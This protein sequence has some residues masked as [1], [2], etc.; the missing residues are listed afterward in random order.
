MP[1]KIHKMLLCFAIVFGSFYWSMAQD[2][3]NQN[4]IYSLPGSF[5]LNAKSDGVKGTP[6]LFEVTRLGKI[7]LPG[8]KV[9]EEIPFN[10]LLEKNEVY[11]QMGGE[12][13]PPMVVKKWDWIE[14]LEDNPRTFKTETVGGQARVVELIYEKDK[15]KIIAIHSKTLVKNEIVRDGYSGPQYDTYRHNVQFYKMEAVRSEE[16]KLNNAGL[17]SIAG[18]RFEELKE[19]IKLEKLK[20][21]EPQDLRRIFIFLETAK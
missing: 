1:S 2:L 8:G 3:Q 21:E 20:P 19:F 17:K 18:N 12:D 9:Y 14:T 4:K 6:F 7:S 5:R 16:L 10:I 11:I 15:V 13:N